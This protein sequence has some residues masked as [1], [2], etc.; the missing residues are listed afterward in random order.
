MILAPAISPL[1]PYTTLFRSYRAAF[2]FPGAS[3]KPDGPHPGRDSAPRQ[4]PQQKVRAP[5]HTGGRKARSEEHTSE[6]QSP[7]HLVCRL[8]LEKNNSAPRGRSR[9]PSSGAAQVPLFLLFNDTCACDISS[10]SLHDALPILSC[11]LPVS[12]SFKKT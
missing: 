3:K 9:C 12:R 2:R 8:L 7:V 10:L 11:S 6:L 5:G 4:V 1:F